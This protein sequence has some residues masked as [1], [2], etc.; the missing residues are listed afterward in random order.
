[1]IET[2]ARPVN[3]EYAN[4]DRKRTN[5]DMTSSSPSTEGKKGFD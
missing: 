4:L 3:S 2:L 1:M 5:G